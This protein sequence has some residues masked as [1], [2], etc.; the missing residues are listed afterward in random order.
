M[1]MSDEEKENGS[2]LL[3]EIKNMPI[4]KKFLEARKIFLWGPVM[5]ES[6]KD[7]VGKL[8]Y[9]EMTD[10]GKEITFYINSPGGSVTAGM[11]I[12]D[13]MK[14]ISSPVATVC[15]GLAASMGSLLLSAGERGRRFIWPN[16]RVMIHQP[17]IGGQIVA[18]ATDIKI[19]AEEIKK[20]KEILNKILSEACNQPFEKVVQDTDRDYYMNAEEAVQYGIVDSLLNSIH[21]PK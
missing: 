12:F 13:T 2:E 15:M 16:G 4:Q 17:S 21:V 6:A 18:P 1:I 3:E 8:L 14:L 9:L 20:T 10:P 19:H 7:I 5:D 11:T